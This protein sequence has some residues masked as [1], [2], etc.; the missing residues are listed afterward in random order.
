LG[1]RGNGGQHFERQLDIRLSVVVDR[2]LQ[3]FLA[4]GFLE[5]LNRGIK[6]AAGRNGADQGECL[7]EAIALDH[8]LGAIEQEAIRHGLGNNRNRGDLCHGCFRD[9]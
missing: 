2:P 5:L 9:R 4:P 7:L 3:E 1:V 8:L 6:F